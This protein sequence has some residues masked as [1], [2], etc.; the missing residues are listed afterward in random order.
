MKP[1]Y[2]FTA[3]VS[4]L[5]FLCG[6]SDF[7]DIKT[8]GALV[9][10]NLENYRYL[11][12][13][14]Y[15]YEIGPQLPDIASDDVELV[16]NSSQQQGLVGSEYYAWFPR[17]YTWQSEIYP[18]GQ[19][20]S[21]PNWNS[22]YNTITYCN[23]VINEVP[24]L[25]EG[26]EAEKQALIAEALTH[27][28]DAY[29]MLVN[30]YAKP[31]DAASAAS[32][33]GV[34]LVLT[35]TVTQS[36]E[37]ASVET[38]YQTIISDLTTALGHLPEKQEYNTLPSRS[39]A[40]AEL[41]RAHLCMNDYEKANEYAELALSLKSTLNDL[42]V[43][44]ELSSVTYPQR[45]NN[46]EIYLSK[47]AYGGISAYTPTALRLSD[48]L[49]QLLGTKDQRYTL[50]TTGAET[51]SPTYADAGGRY[52]Y[53]D[54]ALGETRN[55]GPSVPEM[56]LIRAEYLAR[57]NQPDQAMSIVND[58]RKKRF[59]SDDY[60]A[61]TASGTDDALIKVI[62]ERRLEFFCRML[63]WWDMRRLKNDSRFAKTITRTFNDQTFT[64]A[65][66]SN[67]YVFPIPAYQV[68]LNPE[69]EQ[70]PE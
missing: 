31:Y 23:V 3:Y 42:S 66:A 4:L 67:R 37:R 55:I 2:A 70:N 49:L 65:P 44:T 33:P 29:L 52:F 13:Y 11:L 43:I 36:L 60:A 12:N 14:T 7:V 32:D 39:S 17:S 58:L 25:S 53:K 34:P 10:E 15:A 9:P 59:L 63:R 69:I 18:I 27:R 30:M 16:N 62:E 57:N 61:L 56:M 26:T 45:V 41:A 40:Y 50:F 6:C 38:V 20:Q 47:I 64:L 46:P 22:M 24:S 19:Y 5:L 1:I 68:F 35:Q 48:D 28:A 51:I 8:Q 54:R 21:D